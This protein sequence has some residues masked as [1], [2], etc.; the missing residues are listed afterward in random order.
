MY[1]P[2]S[3]LVDVYTASEDGITLTDNKFSLKYDVIKDKTGLN[4]LSAN[5]YGVP[6]DPGTIGRLTDL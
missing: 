3:A 5:L 1:I 6:G 4:A 2:V